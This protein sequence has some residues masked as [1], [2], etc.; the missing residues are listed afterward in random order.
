MPV[1][2]SMTRRRNSNRNFESEDGVMGQLCSSPHKTRGCFWASTRPQGV[3][4]SRDSPQAVDPSSDDVPIDEATAES[5]RERL[6]SMCRAKV[7]ARIISG[8]MSC[9]SGAC[10]RGRQGCHFIEA[11]WKGKCFSTTLATLTDR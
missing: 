9:G 10:R 6:T 8:E 11:S 2:G 3:L 7:L 1:L 5:M 4:K